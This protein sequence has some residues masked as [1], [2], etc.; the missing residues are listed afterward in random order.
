MGDEEVVTALLVETLVQMDDE[1]LPVGTAV[2][3]KEEVESAVLELK[4]ADEGGS[5]CDVVFGDPDVGL[6]PDLDVELFSRPVAWDV[7]LKL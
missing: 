1:L 3:D 4:V 7:L 6:P 5:I 2:L